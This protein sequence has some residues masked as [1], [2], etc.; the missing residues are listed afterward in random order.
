MNPLDR[1]I[2]QLPSKPQ[3]GTIMFISKSLFTKY[4]Y[5]FVDG[6]YAGIEVK[7]L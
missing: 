4:K 6:K 7:T 1:Y 5:L 3:K 2:S